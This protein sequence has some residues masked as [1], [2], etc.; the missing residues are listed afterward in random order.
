MFKRSI[1]FSREKNSSINLSDSINN[2]LSD[3]SEILIILTGKMILDS[4]INSRDKEHIATNLY[5]SIVSL[6]NKK[7]IIIDENLERGVDKLDR[8]MGDCSN[9]DGYTMQRT[10]NK[11]VFS[12][13]KSSG[14]FKIAFLKRLSLFL[15]LGGIGKKTAKHSFFR[16]I[17]NRILEFGAKSENLDLKFISN[18]LQEFFEMC[19][20]NITH[21]DYC[22]YT[23]WC[24]DVENRISQ[25]IISSIFDVY[26]YHDRKDED[27]K[28]IEKILCCF[29]L[30][31]PD[32]SGASEGTKNFKAKALL[33]LFFTLSICKMPASRIIK[34]LSHLSKI[35]SD[36]GLLPGKGYIS[37]FPN[38]KD[39]AFI[40]RR[41]GLYMIL[42]FYSESLYHCTEKSNLSLDDVRSKVSLH[43]EQTAFSECCRYYKDPFINRDKSNILSPKV[44]TNF[45]S[46]FFLK[47]FTEKSK[48][49]L[50]VD[51]SGDIL[52]VCKII[53]LYCINV[54]W[55]I[56]QDKI[57]FSSYSNNEELIE[58]AFG[59]FDNSK[60]SIFEIMCS[61]FSSSII[62]AYSSFGCLDSSEVIE[63]VLFG[64]ISQRI[65]NFCPR[66]PQSHLE[67]TLF[68][69]NNR[70]CPDEYKSDKGSDFLSKF[71]TLVKSNN[72]FTSL[73]HK[74]NRRF[75][76]SHIMKYKS[77]FFYEGC[78]AKKL[79]F[80]SIIEYPRMCALI[81]KIDEIRKNDKPNN[82]NSKTVCLILDSRSQEIDNDALD[83]D[84]YM[85]TKYLRSIDTSSS[86]LSNIYVSD[87]RQ[88]YSD[89]NLIDSIFLSLS[90]NS[91]IFGFKI[92]YD[93]VYDVEDIKSDIEDS[94]E[95]MVKESK[96][97]V[98]TISI[99]SVRMGI[100]R[101]RIY[102]IFYGGLIDFISLTRTLFSNAIG[103]MEKKDKYSI[104]DVPIYFPSLF[105]ES[106]IKVR[107]IVHLNY[108]SRCILDSFFH[109]N[110]D[111]IAYS[112]FI[113]NRDR[114]SRGLECD[115][116]NEYTII[117]KN[118]TM[119]DFLLKN[120]ESLSYTSSLCLGKQSLINLTTS[121]K[122]TFV[123]NSFDIMSDCALD[124]SIIEKE[125]IRNYVKSMCNMS[126]EIKNNDVS[127]IAHD[128]VVSSYKKTD[129]VFSRNVR[130]SENFR[131]TR[132]ESISLTTGID[133][134]NSFLAL[135]LNGP[136]VRM[137][138]RRKIG[139]FLIDYRAL[140]ILKKIE[141]SRKLIGN[142]SYNQSNFY[143]GEVYKNFNISS[144][145]IPSSSELKINV[146]E[147]HC[148]DVNI[149]SA[150][151]IDVT[152]SNHDRINHSVDEN[153]SSLFPFLKSLIML[154]EYNKQKLLSTKSEYPKNK[155]KYVNRYGVIDKQSK[156]ICIVLDDVD[157]FLKDSLNDCAFSN[158]Y[159]D[160]IYALCA[161]DSL[162]T[163]GILNRHDLSNLFLFV[164][165][166]TH[167][168][169]SSQN[170]CR[171]FPE[172]YFCSE[173]IGENGNSSHE[174]FK[175][176][177]IMME[178]SNEN[179]LIEKKTIFNSLIKNYDDSPNMENKKSDVVFSVQRIP[180]DK[181]ASHRECKSLSSLIQS[182][183]LSDRLFSVETPIVFGSG[184]K[185]R[186]SLSYR[187]LNAYVYSSLY[188]NNFSLRKRTYD[189]K[190]EKSGESIDIE[191][192]S[193][194]DFIYRGNIKFS[195]IARDD[196]CCIFVPPS[197]GDG[198]ICGKSCEFRHL[199][200]PLFDFNF[201]CP[202]KNMNDLL[203]VSMD[204]KSFR[205]LVNRRIEWI[206]DTFVSK[207]VVENANDYNMNKTCSLNSICENSNIGTLSG[208]KDQIAD[209]FWLSLC[210]IKI[211][212]KRLAVTKKS[213]VS[214]IKCGI[215]KE[216]K[217]SNNSSSSSSGKK[218]VSEKEM[219]L[220]Y[221]LNESIDNSPARDSIDK[222]LKSS[223][224][225]MISSCEDKCA[226][227]FDMNKIDATYPL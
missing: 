224:T 152:N 37:K 188:V 29:L 17:E 163:Y 106:G 55:S 35:R 200:F 25:S 150:E 54:N 115:S 67:K 60:S 208:K 9:F 61:L 126:C 202:L 99:R 53:S 18:Y 7:T 58:D 46:T 129:D 209:F 162:I 77:N 111:A 116:S 225:P 74:T 41:L 82:S 52:C 216:M 139:T 72:Y 31:K 15:E 137:G 190:L 33:S 138:D 154:L 95:M 1:E 185:I 23:I 151:M 127:S 89:T 16:V 57:L 143:Q 135:L 26:R 118:K 114:N 159:C 110:Y 10:E 19:S 24:D 156:A 223:D 56:S 133:F 62:F 171:Y 86:K 79:S 120:N 73:D 63:N 187:F 218:R 4:G 180:L 43:V 214:K 125:I 226:F 90:I 96:G 13:S 166:S 88:I 32:Y 70:L 39:P 30:F 131:I 130:N 65:N 172:S 117:S 101:E 132:N 182:M 168:L 181:I 45:I 87:R 149:F 66:I 142:T 194:K 189:V 205:G 161:S 176:A 213:E 148:I 109:G 22:M 36:R 50:P 81:K 85:F 221:R 211:F 42:Y 51:S 97:D 177:R 215:E 104:E 207:K 6:E 146:E 119:D 212:T 59:Y 123:N 78:S 40:T 21:P 98:S 158:D 167:D 141:E 219:K 102:I 155:K 83:S 14:D 173:Y 157:N 128:S 199:F 5:S 80:L 197:D 222:C 217:S 92:D 198:Y 122:H 160:M 48:R 169:I 174:M 144:S 27:K 84:S 220:I 145:T 20:K 184:F 164:K 34:E 93:K 121:K 91:S 183:S 11:I 8:I 28:N 47:G 192:D 178:K 147:M 165:F 206:L 193:S 2:I 113:I 94:K 227:D 68:C 170:I 38:K 134:C 44:C 204:I 196:G 100:D 210:N 191:K 12:E 153:A 76:F 49:F 201:D 71:N 136:N 124:R 179:S 112:N 195:T 103:F 75:Y 186:E 105:G 3:V 140:S 69:L 64:E 108:L 175:I 107:P 203:D